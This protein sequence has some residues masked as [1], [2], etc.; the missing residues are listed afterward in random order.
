[1]VS[2]FEKEADPLSDVI[3]LTKS[4]RSSTDCYTYFLAI[5]A[6]PP[7]AGNISGLR[8]HGCHNSAESFLVYHRVLPQVC[9][10]A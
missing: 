8:W 1:M 2:D 4:R 3:L 7:G 9:G 6:T 5:F 10:Q